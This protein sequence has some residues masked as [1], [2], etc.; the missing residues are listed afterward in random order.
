MVDSRAAYEQLRH[1]LKRR[2][3]E[4]LENGAS[5]DPRT[6]LDRDAIAGELRV[7]LQAWRRESPKPALSAQEQER[8]IGE[9]VDEFIGLGPLEPW[10][11]DPDVTEIMINGP[12]QVY[13]ERGGRLERTAAAFRDTNHLMSVIERLLDSAGLSV[14]SSEPCVDA[15]LPDGSRVNV[16]IPP[17]VL[18]GPTVTIRKKLRPWTVED[19]LRLESLS[20][21]A[22]EFLDACVKA[23]VNLVVSGGTSTGKT[24]LVS[25]L[26][27]FIP[28]TERIITI[29]NVA[30]LELPHHEHWIR[31]VGRA[32]NLEGKGEISL[33]TLVR[34]ALR[35]RPD[36]LILGEA[37][38]GEALDVV[39]AMNSGHD[40]IVTVLH[41]TSPHAA[42]ER[43]QTLML[44]SGLELPSEACQMQIA[45]GVDVVVHMS[46]FADG[47]RRVGAIAQVLDSIEG[48]FQV[49]ELFTFEVRGFQDTGRLEGA[50]RYT[51]ARP[52]VVKKFRLHNVPVPAWVTNKERT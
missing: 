50:L 27:S 3:V 17:L 42:L 23:K 30:E 24:T 43:L 32:P 39:Q 12:Q 15:S 49:E 4:R 22:A 10:L 11:I 26:S 45:R 20:A 7:A 5:G 9:V 38:S 36:R 2:V 48:G 13:V 46:R 33:R 31:L 6:F 29:E 16:I 28:A 19:F 14:T 35:M 18:T 52:K 34:N 25:I 40:G 44:M 51:G 21:Q 41:A 37:R 47:S 8:L 1:L